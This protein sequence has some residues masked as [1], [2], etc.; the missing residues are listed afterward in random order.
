VV[1]DRSGGYLYFLFS[2]YGGV[3]RSQGVAVARMAVEDRFT[4]VGRV[5][6]Y[7]DGGWGQPG[8]GGSV[9]A[10]FPARAAW[11][12]ANTN[13]YWGP[14]VHW[15]GYLGTYVMLLNHSCC[16]A[17]W[18]QKDVRI[19][20]NG[21]PSNPAGWSVPETIAEGG[22][23]AWYPQVLGFGPDATD[24]EAG[25]VVRFYMYGKSY[26]KIIF[27]RPGEPPA[28]APPGDN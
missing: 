8:I 19:S 27:H 3:R 9:T 26:S 17:G 1:P 20:Y 16:R 18:P 22:R 12:R 11:Q 2:N 25:K 14:S 6:K 23:A 21:D 10:V 24:S 7:F 28:A 13:A 5:W 15:N 4:P